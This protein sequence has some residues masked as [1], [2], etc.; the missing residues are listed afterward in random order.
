LS[1]EEQLRTYE[2]IKHVASIKGKL[3]AGAW[4]RNPGFSDLF[5]DVRDALARGGVSTH[6]TKAQLHRL[7]LIDEEH[8][9]VP[10]AKTKEAE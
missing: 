6:V 7:K 9:K 4:F 3:K 5:C 1:P 2:A 10:R 8:L